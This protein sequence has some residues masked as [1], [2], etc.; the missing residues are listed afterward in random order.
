MALGDSGRRLAIVFWHPAELVLLDPKTGAVQA[1]LRACGDA[2]DACF[3]GQRHRLYVSC[4]AGAVEVFR[5]DAMGWR[6]LAVVKTAPGAR[7]L[8]FV[9]GLDQLYVA[10]PARFG[11]P[12][13]ILVFRPLP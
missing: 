2:D 7:T 1:E 10:A 13:R 6:R 9:P 11:M 3:D 5:H 12:A 8:L 4:G